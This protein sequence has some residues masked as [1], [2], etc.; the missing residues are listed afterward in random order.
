[1]ISIQLPKPLEK[2]LKEV[3]QESYSGDMELAIKALLKLHEKYGWK[4]QL[5]ADVRSVRSEVREKGGIKAKRIDDAIRSYR[6][7]KGPSDA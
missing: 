2:H 6:E 4:E 1:M 7:G 5:L 3:V